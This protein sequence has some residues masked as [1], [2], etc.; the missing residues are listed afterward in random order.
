MNADLVPQGKL[1]L[2]PPVPVS[3]KLETEIKTFL[4]EFDVQDVVIN[5]DLHHAI[6][7]LANPEDT[8]KVVSM[9]GNAR[10]LYVPV[11]LSVFVT[12]KLL[13]IAHLPLDITEWKFREIVSQHGNVEK[14][15]L[16]R[17][18]ETGESKGYGF[19]EYDTI[20]RCNQNRTMFDH[21]DISGYKVHCDIIP[22]SL[23]NYSKLHSRCL[24]IDN[25]PR[26]F[27][28]TQDL[29]E[30]FSK[31]FS[32]LYCQIVT[33]EGVSLG[34]GIVE[35]ATA[36]EAEQAQ[37]K[38]NKHKI[39]GT[40][41]RL[42]YCIPSKSAVAISNRIM[43]KYGDTVPSNKP[44]LL[45]DPVYPN[46]ALTKHRL[47]KTL[48]SKNSQILPNFKEAL[49]LLQQGYVCQLENKVNSKPGLLGPAPKIPMSPLMDMSVQ[50]GLLCLV[51][52]HM[53]EAN[54]LDK[55]ELPNPLNTL[56]LAEGQKAVA[57]GTKPSL[58]GDPVSAQASIALQHL[59][60][61]MD[62]I[63]TDTSSE[64]TQQQQPSAMEMLNKRIKS[65]NILLLSNLGQ[66]VANVHEV[67]QDKGL[68][69]SIPSL[70]QATRGLFQD[71]FKKQKEERSGLLGP[72]PKFLGSAPNFMNTV[73]TLALQ[74]LTE[75]YGNQP[76]FMN[77]LFGAES[78]NDSRDSDGQN[79][80]NRSGNSLLGQPPSM[81]GGGNRVGSSLLPKPDSMGLLG[82]GGQGMLRSSYDTGGYNRDWYDESGYQPSSDDYSGYSH[83]GYRD[84]SYSDQYYDSNYNYYGENDRDP[85]SQ[86][87]QS[88]VGYGGSYG[89]TMA[90][91]DRYR[92][93]APPDVP[94]GPGM[95]MGVSA[96]GTRNPG[97]NRPPPPPMGGSTSYNMANYDSG[98][99]SGSS[100]DPYNATAPPLPPPLPATPEVSSRRPITE[101]P[102]K[103]ANSAEYQD[104]AEQAAA[105]AARA[106]AGTGYNEYNNTPAYGNNTYGSYGNN[107]GNNNYGN[108][109]YGNYGSDNYGG[110][111][112]GSGS[113]GNNTYGGN[114]YSNYMRDYNSGYN[115]PPN[116]S[117]PPPPPIGTANTPSG[118]KRSYSQLLPP[119]E[120]SPEGDYVG[121]HSQGIGGHYADSITAK[122][123]RLDSVSKLNLS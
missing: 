96:L 77:V 78:E 31:E 23:M 3:G 46:P 85:Y 76:Q 61:Q 118:Q 113:Y 36:E 75:D 4:S 18:E 100:N 55:A 72:A 90:Q 71:P 15:F 81:P 30:I 119:P 38:M 47:V 79:Y 84:D 111:G 26:E 107:Y 1:D 51:I 80:G 5:R 60:S 62:T 8:E 32:P 33:K 10:L 65:V 121:Q 83:E 63:E 92:Q 93:G 7:T 102:I 101:S 69:G 87:Y 89:D 56:S 28:E 11:T 43:T 42:T 34:F 53:T 57:A 86:D 25:L 98:Y 21:M 48:S 94:L 66:I 54:E 9:M 106:R 97:D 117:M 82:Q 58:L 49:T 109:N 115:N 70:E 39:G 74:K 29:R 104:V 17:S 45:P 35:Y 37:Q 122:R 6:V 59:L 105:Y 120:P 13:C 112:Y 20:E 24:L 40:E 114:A 91:A 110:S 2:C 67:S 41:V 14:C 123:Q 95:N 27:K 64:S 50:M 19:V 88:Q 16:M 103:G 73:K 12:N 44:S 52:L 22:D 116:S 68:L 108:S 99:Y